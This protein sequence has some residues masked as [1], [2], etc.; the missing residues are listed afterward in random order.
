MALLPT[1]MPAE[2]FP[3]FTLFRGHRNPD[4]AAALQQMIGFQA[5]PR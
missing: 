4:A 1:N 5:P 3:P 2:L